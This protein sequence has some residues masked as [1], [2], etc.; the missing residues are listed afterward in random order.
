MDDSKRFESITITI[1]A[2][3]RAMLDELMTWWHPTDGRVISMTIREC[4][5]ETHK[6]EKA[7]RKRMGK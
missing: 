5:R 6:R 4:I 1:T 7:E 2:V 3:E